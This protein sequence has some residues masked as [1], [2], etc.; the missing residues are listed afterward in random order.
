MR[1]C[2][3][4]VYVAAPPLIT[5]DGCGAPLL[6][7]QYLLSQRACSFYLAGYTGVSPECPLHHTNKIATVVARS[8]YLLSF[9]ANEPEWF[10]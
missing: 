4:L 1:S 2:S 10:M 9:G 3:A 8:T 6:F 5:I 7:M